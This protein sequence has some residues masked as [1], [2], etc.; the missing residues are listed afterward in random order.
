MNRPG[1]APRALRRVCLCGVKKA[2]DA[3]GRMCYDDCTSF[4]G[5]FF[6]AHFSV[7]R[8]REREAI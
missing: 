6:C 3:R 8:L 7:R 1:E 2:L 5:L 4:A